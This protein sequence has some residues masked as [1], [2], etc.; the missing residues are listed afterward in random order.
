[1]KKV[2]A[3]FKRPIGQFIGI[4][5]LVVGS[6]YL[7]RFYYVDMPKLRQT[8]QAKTGPER[9]IEI[10]EKLQSEF[11]R[12]EDGDA[13][14]Q[15]LPKRTAWNP[16]TLE[17]GASGTFDEGDSAFWSMLGV[18]AVKET[19]FQYRFER[20]GDAYLL[21]ARRDSD[22]DGLHVVH[23]LRGNTDWTAILRDANIESKNIDE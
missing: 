9:V 10:A 20:M 15:S 5:L 6:A 16:A 3:F 4:G 11:T 1:M 12:A 17:C 2:I 7:G 19:L 8:E 21:R 13:F 14:V 22:C 18:E 23:L